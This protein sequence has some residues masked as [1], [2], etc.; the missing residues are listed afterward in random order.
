[1]EADAGEFLRRL[2]ERVGMLA[3]SRASWRQ[4]AGEPGAGETPS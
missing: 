1:V 4:A 3:A 2:I